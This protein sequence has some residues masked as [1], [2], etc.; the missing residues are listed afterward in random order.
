MIPPLPELIELHE[1]IAAGEEGQGRGAA[2][3]TAHL[4]EEGARRS[5]ADAAETGLPGDD[6]VRFGAARLLDLGARRRWGVMTSTVKL[7]ALFAL[8]CACIGALA[9]ARPAEATPRFGVAEDATKYA[10]DGDAS[11][12]LRLRSLRMVENRIAVRWNPAEPTEILEQKFLDRA[13]PPRHPARYPACVRRLLDR[14]VRIR[15]RD[16]DA[17][18]ALRVLPP[19]GRAAYPQVT[20]FIVANEPNERYFWR[21]QFTPAGVQASGA[22]FLRSRARLR[23]AEGGQPEDPRHRRGSR[24]RATTGRPRRPCGS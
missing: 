14:P 16:R 2:L 22:D 17:R 13:V 8:L 12:Y 5:I 11:F 4:D 6:P 24:A 19:E 7:K 3:N 9:A 21:P 18:R 20:D 15:R 1:R 10:E 23:R